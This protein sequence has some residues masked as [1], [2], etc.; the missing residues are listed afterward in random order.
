MSEDCEE[1]RTPTGR[2]PVDLTKTT[3]SFKTVVG[4]VVAICAAIIAGGTGVG[5][6]YMDLTWEVHRMGEALNDRPTTKD[7]DKFRVELG[8]EVDRKVAEQTKH[9]LARATSVCVATKKGAITC[10]YELP[11]FDDRREAP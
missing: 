9:W 5:K 7:W 6:A 2:R 1:D 4:V 8:A 11:M 3:L 10:R